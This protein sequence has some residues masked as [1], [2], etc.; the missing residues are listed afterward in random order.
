MVPGLA[1]SSV[2]L[3][4][5][6]ASTALGHWPVPSVDDPKYL[7]TAP[8]HVVSALLLL[9]VVPGSAIVGLAAAVSW[10]ALRRPSVQWMWLAIFAASWALLGYSRRSDAATWAWW[11]D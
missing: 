9:L 7:V 5:L 11:F 8:L 6:L 10:R 1:V 3:E 2:Y 4:G